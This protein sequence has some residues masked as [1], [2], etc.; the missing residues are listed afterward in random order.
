MTS[1]TNKLNVTVMNVENFC[2][3]T[4]EEKIKHDFGAS[5]YHN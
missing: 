3:E 1:P 2:N 4:R 5:W